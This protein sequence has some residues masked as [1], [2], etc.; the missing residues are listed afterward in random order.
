[1]HNNQ[2]HNAI[3]LFIFSLCLFSGKSAIAQ[4]VPETPT[5]VQATPSRE[6]QQDRERLLSR[7]AINLAL[8]GEIESAIA[9][10]Q[11]I[12]E[13][14]LQLNAWVSIAEALMKQ[15]EYDR[16]LS[17]V[18]DFELDEIGEWISEDLIYYAIAA[19]DARQGRGER[20]IATA[21]KI[22]NLRYRLLLVDLVEI[23]RKNED[24]DSIVTLFLT[25][26]PSNA[27][28]TLIE[29]L[30]AA[31]GKTPQAQLQPLLQILTPP[32]Q[33]LALSRMAIALQEQ[34]NPNTAKT[35]LA[36]AQAI[37]DKVTQVSDRGTVELDLIATWASLQEFE[38]AMS[39]LPRLADTP[40]ISNQGERIIIIE[41]A[42]AGR[43]DEAI[44]L[45]RNLTQDVQGEVLP[46]VAIQIVQKGELSRIPP[47]LETFENANILLLRELAV[48][49]T[50]AGDD[51]QALQIAQIYQDD[52]QYL[53]TLGSLAVAKAERGDI[54][55]AIAL[56]PQ[57]SDLYRPEAISKILQLVLEA[58]NYDTAIALA[59]QGEAYQDSL[60]PP[61]LD[62]VIFHLAEKGNSDR[63]LQL[64]AQLP[65]SPRSRK[66]YELIATYLATQGEKQQL[67][68][69]ISAWDATEN[70]DPAWML[71]TQELA[72]NGNLALALLLNENIQSLA[73]RA[74]NLGAIAIILPTTELRTSEALSL[75]NRSVQIADRIRDRADKSETYIK[76]SDYYLEIG[77]SP[78]A[79]PLLQQALAL[80]KN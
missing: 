65:E 45:T 8:A 58:E 18:A 31:A 50:L 68:A 34:G 79:I 14:V 27:N 37:W 41:L 71:I 33:A 29:T 80:I 23:L 39:V 54:P 43:F 9:T 78:A 55:D 11:E 13:S 15:G 24:Y 32:E 16:A 67:L 75:L 1:T 36:E 70:R 61:Y 73:A 2:Y 59:Q 42:K 26:P 17:L 5:I 6:A 60:A 4:I 51:E 30:E 49:L 10:A 46:I 20:A 28:S 3:A 64:A 38:R 47:L 62:R 69:L 53:V 44:A 48:A 12:T 63:A 56:L 40:E 76:I 57:V 22:D 7:I 52:V 72:Q 25:H 21:Q 19:Y 74:N 66:V 77:Q 35:L